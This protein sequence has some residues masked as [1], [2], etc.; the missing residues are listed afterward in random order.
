MRSPKSR[1]SSTARSC[2]NPTRP[3]IRLLSSSSCEA[4]PGTPM[5]GTASEMTT[6]IITTTTK[7]STSV[8]PLLRMARR[9]RAGSLPLFEGRGADVGVVAVTAGF[10]VASVARDVVIAS[11]G[12]RIDVLIRIVPRIL[13][14]GRQVAAGAIIGDSRV[15]RLGHERLQALFRRR[16]FVIIPPIEIERGLNGANIAGRAR[17]A[18]FIGVLQD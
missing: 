3:S 2:S 15:R 10:A 9:P 7:I 16:V 14:Q 13:R 1:P 12:A 17:Y 5:D 8:K 18:R 11:I 6:A 4:R